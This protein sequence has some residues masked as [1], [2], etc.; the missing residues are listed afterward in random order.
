[1]YAVIKTGGKQYK[2]S[3]GDK[4]FIEKLKAEA[5]EK[6]SFEEVLIVGKDGTVNV[7]KPFIEGAIVEAKVVKHGKNKKVL[8]MHYK[9]KKDLHKKTG[10]RQ[11]YTL[12]EITAIKA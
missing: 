11:P 7:G 5:D 9:P 10:H 8:K 4:V 3:E 12:V 2:V 1:M 6:V